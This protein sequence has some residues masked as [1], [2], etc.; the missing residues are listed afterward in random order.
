[1]SAPLRTLDVRTIL[2][3]GGEPFGEIMKATAAL[4]DGQGLRLLATFNPVPLYSIM[5]GKGYSHQERQIEGGDWEVILMPRAAAAAA[6][7]QA[8]PAT[9]GAV[10]TAGWP[11]PSRT[12]DLRGML[13]PEPLVLT[14]ETLEAMAVGEVM[15]GCYDREPLLLYPELDVRGHP[16]QCDKRGANEYHVRI[17][18]GADE[19]G[20]A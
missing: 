7:A 2:E 19:G 8:A 6:A 20:A 5:E 12:V 15:E 18:R 1:M 10:D 9:T 16:Y 3:A 17:R 14:L 13:P 11:A 4:E